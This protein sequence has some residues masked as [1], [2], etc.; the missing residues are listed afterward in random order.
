MAI[1][2]ADSWPFY[3]RLHTL[4]RAWRYR[5]RTERDEIRYMLSCNLSGRTVLDIGAHRGAYTYWMH[6]LVAPDGHVVAFEPQ[7]ELQAYLTRMADAF[8]W[9]NFTLAPIALSAAPGR[10]NLVRPKAQW[11]YGGLDTAKSDDTEQFPVDVSTLDRFFDGRPELRPVC[12]VKCDVQDHELP[13]FQGGETILRD[14]RPILL[15]ECLDEFVESGEL[16]DF[17]YS[18]NYSGYFFF[19]GALTPI[20]QHKDLRKRIDLPYLN[21]VFKP[22]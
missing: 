21:F 10:Q 7:P 16:F 5:L 15:F 1:H 6:R 17:L 18:L 12:F 2:K 22:V 14:D 9:A 3:M 11:G 4:H 13:V 8:G 20:A 19:N